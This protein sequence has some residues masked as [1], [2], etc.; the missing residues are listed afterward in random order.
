[1]WFL[2]TVFYQIYMPSFKDGNGDGIGDFK[3]IIE[4]LPYLKDLGVG[5]IWLTPFYPSPKVDN[6]YDISDYKDVDEVYGTISDFDNFLNVAHELGI[7]VIIDL[8]INHTSNK[9]KWFTMA[10]SSLDNEYRD[11]YIWKK[12]I[13]NNWESFFAGS[14]WEYDEKTKEYY[15]H[16]FSKEQVCLNWQNPKVKNEIFDVMKFWLD[17]GVDGFRLDV[18][19]FL[20]VNDSLFYKDN[21]TKDDGRQEH[22][23]DQNQDGILDYIKKIS[24]Y[25]KQWDN[26]FLLGEVG[27][28]DIGILSKYVGDELLDCVFNFNLGSMKQLDVK[29][30]MDNLLD[31]DKS[32]K[33]PTI[34]FSS[35]DMSRCTT[36]LCNNNEDLQKVLAGLLLTAKGVPFLY[37]G[38]EFGMV[39]LNS[40][41][42]DSIIDVQAKLVYENAIKLGKTEEKALEMANEYCR[43]K[44]RSPL[45]WNK[46]NENFGFS[47]NEP[48]IPFAKNDIDLNSKLCENSSVF[49]F[50][51]NLISIRNNSDVLKYGEYESIY[52]INDVLFIKRTLNDKSIFGIFNFS[53]E[54]LKFDK[55]Y[56]KI[57]ISSVSTED[58]LIKPFEITLMEV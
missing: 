7:K 54:E 27:S 34:F 55:K 56:K 57:I 33:L 8:V 9:H 15:Y 3:G 19:N 2:E 45:Q 20:K 38:D 50:Y 52:K 12:E 5:A 39:D 42:I 13:P 14:A 23:Y 16:A 46:N 24:N 22:L 26:K 32:I 40:Y 48:W 44:S 18:I 43:D 58:N 28:E 30:I 11:Y 4:K 25:V 6:G 35:H 53:N 47:T 49:L 36:R 1:M 17:K 51:Q 21:P 29:L 10:S 37:Q 31:M 41:D